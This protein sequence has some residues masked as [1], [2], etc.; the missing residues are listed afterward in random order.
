MGVLLFDPRWA[1]QAHVSGSGELMHVL[2]GQ[3]ELELEGAHYV[4]AP[5]D[6]L[7]VPPGSLHRD[8]FDLDAG[9]QVFLVFF[10]WAAAPAYFSLV[11]NDLLCG[12]PAARKADL[13]LH[14]E[15]MRR[16]RRGDSEADR[17]VARGHLYTL[18]MLID[19]DAATY[20]FAKALTAR[21]FVE[22]I[23]AGAGDA[24]AIAHAVIAR[25]V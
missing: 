10:D 12:L 5:G 11:S 21:V 22:F 14:V 15:R 1:E 2:N 23:Q 7:L 25:E 9:L 24:M 4:A 8:V 13:A 16:D 17:L 20:F 3:V 6:L 18:L 19:Q